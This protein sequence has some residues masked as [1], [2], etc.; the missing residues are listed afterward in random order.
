MNRITVM[1]LTKNEEKHIKELLENLSQ[2]DV[3]ITI[4]DS[5]S[6]DRTVEIAK[7]YNVKIVQHKF[8]SFSKQRNFAL[9]IAETDWVLFLDADERLSPE[10]VD[11]IRNFT[12]YPTFNR[13]SAVTIPRK[14]V[15]FGKRLRFAWKSKEVRLL[16]RSDCTYDEAIPVHERV[17][18]NGRIGK[19]PKG[20]I[21]HYTYYDFEQYVKKMNLGQVLY[22]V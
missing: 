3:P 12:K 7:N 18:V 21:L 17:I 20:Y 5:Y 16:K 8:E 13:F 1:V 2:L 4:V 6:D 11:F 22:F 9:R 10:L 14:T 15:A 19:V